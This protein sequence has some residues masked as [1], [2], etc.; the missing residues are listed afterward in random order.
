MLRSSRLPVAVALFALW[1]AA[2]GC[3][4]VPPRL[5]STRPEAIVTAEGVFGSVATRFTTVTRDPKA[6]V[7]R[8]RIARQALTPAALFNDTAAWLWSAGPDLRSISWRGTVE[9]REM[10]FR[11]GNFRMPTRAGE[12]LHHLQLKRLTDGAYE[13][14]ANVDL[15]IGA[16]TPANVAAIPVAFIAAGER[17]D[18]ASA[19]AEIAS[20]FPRSAQVWG[21]LFTVEALRSE[22][23][24]NGAWRQ[25]HTI[26]LH[27]DRAAQTYPRFGKWLA[28][29]ISP[30]RMHL[31]LR[32]DGRTWFDLTLRG[33]TMTLAFRSRNGALLPLEGGDAPL[34]DTVRMETDFS[35]KLLLFRLGFT[36]LVNDFITV[37]T[38]QRRGWVMR[39]TNEPEWNLPL[40]AERML[41][42]PLRRP[43]TGTGSTLSVIATARSDWPQAAL[44]RSLVV[45]VQDSPILRFLGRLGNA[46][47]D[48]YVN[49]AEDQSTAWI[50]AAFGALRDDARAVLA[51]G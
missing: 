45:P 30:V 29:Y 17:A 46:A 49:G 11:A 42:S 2:A 23:D 13:W 37:R 16:A 19:R 41:R 44:A 26:T 24:G 50:S 3:R 39:F 48:G 35:T 32:Q 22:P 33:D 47:V 28:E 51:G 40:L 5:G 9:G 14:T 7:A 4:S 36:G 15:G 31:R 38:P 1:G 10:H 18:A 34:P 43:F 27:P 21:R 20:A 6:R 25:R 12:G 8:Q